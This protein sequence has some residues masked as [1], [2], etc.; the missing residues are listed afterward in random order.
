MTEL[1]KHIDDKPVRSKRAWVYDTFF[2]LLLLTGAFLR[3]T[4]LN[5]DEG[6]HLHPDERFLTGV[7]TALSTVS[8]FKEY[9]N[10]ETSPLNPHNRG[11]AFF[12]YG[13]LPIILVRYTAEMVDQ[14]G[15]S[16]INL[17]GRQMSAFADLG[18]VFLIYLAAVRLY[19]RRVAILAAAFSTFTVMQIQLSHYF[20][21]DTFLN[22]FALMALYFA[23]QI[24][25]EKDEKVFRWQ[26]FAWF[27]AALG[28]AVASKISAAVIAVMLPVAV[29]A[30]LSQEPEED[31]YDLAWTALGYMVAAAFV[32]LL[33][34]RI[35][36]PYAFRG[37]GFF[38][39]ALNEKWVANIRA[40][41]AQQA[42]DI[43]W[44]PSIQWARRP[45]WFSLQN[46]AFWGQG[47]PL[48]LFAWAGFA[49]IGRRMLQGEWRKHIVLWGWTAL[50]FT[51]QSM[52]FNPTMRY[53][54]LSYPGLA[55]F[56]G[57]A[58]VA[59]WDWAANRPGLGSSARI[60]VRTAAAAA[61][62]AAVILTAL[63]AFAFVQ[64]YNRPVTRVAA[65]AWIYENI[66]GPVNLL[67][68]ADQGPATQLVSFPYDFSILAGQ[69][70]I[71]SF[72]ANTSGALEEILIRQI[73]MP[74][75]EYRFILTLFA[76]NAGGS[77]EVLISI[78][79][80]MEFSKDDAGKPVEL[81][82]VPDI[83][84]SFEP[85]KIYR[86]RIDQ[87]SESMGVSLLQADLY[88]LTATGQEV[89][90]LAEGAYDIDAAHPFEQSFLVSESGGMGQISAQIEYSGQAH[91]P[92]QALSL[93]IKREGQTAAG[94]KLN[95][96]L[97]HGPLKD[98]SIL[99]DR[100]VKL[101]EGETYTLFLE[102]D[103]PT[104][105]A[106]IKGSAVVV[107]TSW[108]DG[109][110][111]RTVYD[112]YGGIYQ[113]EMNLDLYA[114]DNL[115]K[116]DHMLE[117][118]KAA[119]YVTISSSRQ[120][121]STPRIPERYPLVS[122]Y[123]RALLGC[124]DERSIEW[125]YNVAEVGTFKGQLGFELVKVFTSNPSIGALQI[126]DQFSEEAFTVYDHPKVFIFK[127]SAGY[128]HANT[129]AL[130][131]SVDLDNVIRLTPKQ[132]SSRKTSDLM[133][134]ADMLEQQQAGGTWADLFDTDSPVN[135]SGFLTVLVWY[136]SVAVLGWGA[137][138]LVRKALP[139]L[140]DKGYPLART[141]G[142]LIL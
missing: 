52:A 7:E 43:D 37:P 41:A 113:R 76:V 65:S 23:V 46:M 57:W 78:E 25:Q 49:A 2:L 94:A 132:A 32:S 126:N 133:L 99:L 12:V 72:T 120:W 27:G 15:Y 70:Y 130:L 40:L 110:P 114:D 137:Y 97:S 140:A 62:A 124:P 21:V 82:F 96:D 122:A 31:R 73:E 44:P 88:S 36:Q 105:A 69:P 134:P 55:I 80:E 84:V 115:S 128:D 53:Q 125:C 129:E 74:P 68:D 22:L 60:F 141:A 121:A 142:L 8:S 51:W 17:V 93:A 136:M 117:I 14:V 83:P 139:G 54:L 64:I 48:A 66:P 38:N 5:W 79:V 63:W 16:E 81:I 29:F 102:M 39:M 95:I 116:L 77:D 119:D 67:I 20:T 45:R 6:Q 75:D 58:V 26:T 10:T 131:G 56:A 109:L 42:G 100:P 108:D 91:S 24:S 1:S 98:Q 92:Q 87:L 18:V 107:E 89:L 138:P 28:M 33:A 11:N 34:F 85:G 13:T 30:R 135:R 112:G 35:F 86:V 3:L 103:T 111:L 101:N 127:K 90:T 71:T 61:G 106:A 123:Y 59:L 50:F 4:G 104:G 47:L 9:W 118:L 19:D